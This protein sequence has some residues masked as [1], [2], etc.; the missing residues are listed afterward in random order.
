M[1]KVV[2]MKQWIRAF[3]CAM[4]LLLSGS[5]WALDELTPV[6]TLTAPVMDTAQVMQ[7]GER[8]ALNQQLLQYAREKGS[9]IVILTVPAI[10]PE[11]TFD[12]GTRVMDSWK[13]GRQGVDDGVL[14]LV[15]RDERKTQLLVGRGLEGA[16]PDA[17]AK[18]ILSEIVRPYFQAG[19]YDQGII[20]TT[21]QIQ[22]LIAGE[23]SPEPSDS[24]GDQ[25]GSGS[26]LGDGNW[27]LLLFVLIFVSGFLKRIF[28]SF[29]GSMA[30]GAVATGLSMM[31]GSGL[32]LALVVGFGFMLLSLLLGA[33]STIVFPSG[34]SGG[35]WGSG[36]SGGG[37]G[38]GFSGGG[39]GFGGGGASGGW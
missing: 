13:L 25:S 3:V 22:K 9:Q 21:N 14:L 34:S 36:S 2:A 26:G 28:G 38:G 37:G 24:Y 12:Y 4:G 6:P 11:T 32:V 30:S 7:A 19:Q 10:A 17:Y 29:L 35:H 27:L 23:Q 31:F 33:G 39:G 18:R 16:I 20:A 8:E 1:K 5:L 15:V